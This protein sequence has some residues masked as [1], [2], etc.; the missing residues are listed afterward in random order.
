MYLSF[1]LYVLRWLNSHFNWNS[2]LIL[3]HSNIKKV[4]NRCENKIEGFVIGQPDDVKHHW[5]IFNGEHCNVDILHHNVVFDKGASDITKLWCKSIFLG[6][7]LN[8][9]WV[10]KTII[11]HKMLLNKAR[12]IFQKLLLGSLYLES[13]LYLNYILS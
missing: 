5:E 1:W 6:V 10:L 13:A 8:L 9:I 12:V 7:R 3:G 11:P 4:F 2:L